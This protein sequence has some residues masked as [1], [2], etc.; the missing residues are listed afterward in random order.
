[1][2]ELRPGEPRRDLASWS[3]RRRSPSGALECVLTDGTLAFREDLQ[4]TLLERPLERD[5]PPSEGEVGPCRWTRIGFDEMDG[6][7][8]EVRGG[9][10]DGTKDL[11]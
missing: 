7:G 6:E 3:G 4:H 2:G 1:M 5:P 8:F 10:H 9:G 11:D